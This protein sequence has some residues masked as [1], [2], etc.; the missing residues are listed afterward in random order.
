MSAADDSIA[1]LP[2]LPEEVRER[3]M[4]YIL[5]AAWRALPRTSTCMRRNSTTR[6]RLLPH[7][8]TMA[9]D[10]PPR[11]T[12]HRDAPPGQSPLPVFSRVNLMLQLEFFA[13]EERIT[14]IPN[15]EQEDDGGHICCVG[16]SRRRRHSSKDCAACAAH[17]RLF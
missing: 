14:I 11:C 1:K 10:A 8:P 4:L 12:P 9:H 13:E 17:V 15:F 7:I 16:V 3:G 2:M 6:P 5:D